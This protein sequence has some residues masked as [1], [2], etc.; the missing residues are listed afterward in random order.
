VIQATFIEKKAVGTVTPE[1]RGYVKNH[2]DGTKSFQ[3]GGLTV[4]YDNSTIIG[5]LPNPSGGNW[6]DLFVEVKG[7]TFNSGTATLTATKVEPESQA[8]QQADE[9]EVEGFVTRVDGPGDF[10]IGSTHVQTTPSTE[11]RGGTIDEAVEGVKLSAEGRLAD[12]VL[13][14]NHVKFHASVKLEGNVASIDITAKTFTI[15]GLPGVTVN[16]NSLTEFKANG[17]NRIIDL[18]D[19]SMGNH[20]RVRGSV[21][22]GNSVIATRLEQRSGDVDIDLQGPVQA[23]SSPIL[24]ILEIQ[25]DTNTSGFS[26]PDSFQGQNDQPIGQDAFFKFVTVGTLVKVKGRLINGVVTWREAE[27]ED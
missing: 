7:T 17:G 18:N 26:D 16:V 21:G 13:T 27:L 20:V 8:V 23:A 22:S 3:I 5:D 4:A 25:V 24:T 14:A 9:F 10:F 12:G 11:F 2:N 6:N 19:L 15:T 1:V